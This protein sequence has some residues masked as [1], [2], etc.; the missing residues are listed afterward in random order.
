M[1]KKNVKVR[2]GVSSGMKTRKRIKKRKPGF[3][4]QEGFKHAKL[5][6]SWRRP[7]GRHSK[8]RKKEKARG[9]HPSIGYS[10]P[11]SVRGL[12]RFGYREVRVSNPGDIG[13]ID[14]KEEVAI[15]S[16]SVGKRK[17]TEI[18]KAAEEKGVRVKNF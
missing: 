12:D 3:K 17:R 18:V 7:R 1:E 10:S 9:S 16:G 13:K 2:E 4:R 11:R 14:P 6:D 5:A 8:K 15:I